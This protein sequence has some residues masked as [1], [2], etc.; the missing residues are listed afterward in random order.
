[1]SNAHQEGTRPF[2]PCC[3]LPDYGNVLALDTP[4][5]AIRIST[6]V[7]RVEDLLDLE[8]EEVGGVLLMHLNSIR[9]NEDS[10]VHHGSINQ[11]NFFNGLARQPEYPGHQGEVDRVLMEAWGWLE[12]AGFL[13]CEPDTVG[14]RFFVTRRGLSLKSR[15]DLTAYRKA[16]VL[17]NAQIH[18]LIA[19]TVYPAFL[20]GEYDTAIFQAFR[21]IEVAVR[22]AGQFPHDLVGD[23]LMRT[24]FVTSKNNSPGPLADPQLPAGEQEAMGHLFAGAFGLYRNS[25]AHRYVPTE[26]KQAAEVIMFASQL[27]RIVDR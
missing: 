19:R 3:F 27:L 23:K 26:P 22:Q 6:L 12:S 24:A 9:D 2:L 16:S 25:T 11:H 21:E 5:P 18:P 10:L 8:V 20:R 1:V 13:G 7:P 4:V 15:E 14:A 17:P